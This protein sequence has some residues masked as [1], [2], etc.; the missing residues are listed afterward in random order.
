VEPTAMALTTKVT[1]FAFAGI[2]AEAGTVAMDG[3]SETR[4]TTSGTGVT[5][6]SVTATLRDAPRPIRIGSG[7]KLSA[8]V[9]FTGAD[10]DVNPVAD[11]VMFAVPTLTPVTW[12]WVVGVVAPAAI[13]TE[14]GAI[15]TREGL[16][17]TR[18]IVTGFA[19]ATDKL[20]LKGT[21]CDSPTEVL[22]G[23]VIPPPL[24]TDTLAAASGMLGSAAA[25]IV[26]A[27]RATA[28]I[29]TEALSDWAGIVTVAGTVAMP[30]LSE[31][32]LSVRA[33]GV[34]ADSFT[35]TFWL[36]IPVMVICAGTKDTLAVTVADL[37]AFA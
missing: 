26:V 36:V 19:G 20:T 23:N 10:E 16:L 13:V 8:A 2:V 24:W 33:V 25:W 15:V 28:V 22:A 31:R 18:L 32:R 34:G 6:E 7:G 17:L 1:L 21:D 29:W 9:T 12:G 35:V 37:D 4:V 5:A 14:A 3:L 30:V 11:A 27:P